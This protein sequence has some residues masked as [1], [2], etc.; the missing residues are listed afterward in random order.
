MIPT[1]DVKTYLCKI[2]VMRQG[3]YAI[4]KTRNEIREEWERTVG[5][6]GHFTDYLELR[7]F[8]GWS[9]VHLLV[10]RK[11]QTEYIQSQIDDLDGL[12]E[13]AVENE[14][15]DLIDQYRPLLKE[16]ERELSRIK[17]GLE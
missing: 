8:K 17:L 3:G 15:Q 1:I 13:N 12:L 11:W 9:I 10:P 16:W 2:G 6:S 7:H 14:D 5:E 4:S